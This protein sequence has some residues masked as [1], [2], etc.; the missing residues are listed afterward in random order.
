M[1]ERTA[2][3][4]SESLTLKVHV[5]TKGILQKDTTPTAVDCVFFPPAQ[6][7]KSNGREFRRTRGCERGEDQGR[8]EDFVLG[9][10][11]YKCRVY[12]FN[13]RVDT[14]SSG[15]MTGTASSTCRSRPAQLSLRDSIQGSFQTFAGFLNARRVIVATSKL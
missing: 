10:R 6:L 9:T 13:S 3:K 14:W 12:S 1:F 11:V 2:D 8:T 7:T 4:F 5:G 15:S